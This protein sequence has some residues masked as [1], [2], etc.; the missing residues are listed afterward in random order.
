M[1]QRDRIYRDGDTMTVPA[2]DGLPTWECADCGIGRQC[3]CPAA[4]DWPDAVL[5]GEAP[6]CPDCEC[7]MDLIDD[8]TPGE[9]HAAE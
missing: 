6:N 8:P 7:P 9:H 5:R 3:C 2:P 1:P 4:T